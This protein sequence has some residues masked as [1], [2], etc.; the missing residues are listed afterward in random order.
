MMTSPPAARSAWTCDSIVVPVSRV[1]VDRADPLPQPAA[2][3][4]ELSMN[5]KVKTLMPEAFVDRHEILVLP[6]GHIDIGA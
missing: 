3:P 6:Q 1:L 5:A 2:Q 4:P